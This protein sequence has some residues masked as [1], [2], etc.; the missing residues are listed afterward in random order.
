MFSLFYLLTI[1]SMLIPTVSSTVDYGITFNL[2]IYDR[3]QLIM[4]SVLDC[5]QSRCIQIRVIK[6]QIDS[7]SPV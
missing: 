1:F 5:L 3:L 4:L 2:R 7:H 6:D